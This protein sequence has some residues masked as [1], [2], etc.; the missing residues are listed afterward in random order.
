[1]QSP[2]TQLLRA[3]RSSILTVSY[4]T[5]EP[6]SVSRFAPF[7]SHPKTAG[8]FCLARNLSTTRPDHNSDRASS[9]KR[10][11]QPRPSSQRASSLSTA[12]LKP[13]SHHRGPPP[14][15]RDAATPVT[16]LGALNVLANVAAPT[17]AIDACVNDGFHLDNGVKI[18]G[19]NGCFLVDGESFAWR[20]WEGNGKGMRG[21]INNK[22]QWEVAE[23][24][25]GLLKLLW[26]KP[27][28]P[29]HPLS[30]V[31]CFLLSFSPSISFRFCFF[32]FIPPPPIFFFSASSLHP[33]L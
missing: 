14:E 26:P 1:M 10:P 3:L 2:S 9:S 8:P 20:P 27:G 33:R 18:T 21:M 6:A 15:E 32:I 24:A 28:A 4:R 7:V 19:G 5:S 22:G 29:F 16:D 17:T 12:D 11:S 31:H 30:T 13:T 25:W 23:E